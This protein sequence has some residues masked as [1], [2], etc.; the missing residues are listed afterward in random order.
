MCPSFRAWRAGLESEMARRI[1][2]TPASVDELMK[3]YLVDPQTP[4]LRIE[5]G[6]T[7]RK[8]WRYR[9]RL[10]SGGVIKLTLGRY[11]AFSIAAARTWAAELNA[12]VDGFWLGRMKLR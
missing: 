11:P 6:E 7:G 5:V 8:T 4:G 2:L 9:R 10:S 1:V 12:K 3:G